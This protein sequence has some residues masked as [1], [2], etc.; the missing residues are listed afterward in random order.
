MPT[1]FEARIEYNTI[2][3]YCQ[4]E[5]VLDPYVSYSPSAD[6]RACEIIDVPLDVTI[7]GPTVSPNISL[8]EMINSPDGGG[9]SCGLTPTTACLN[10]LNECA[11]GDA[12]CAYISDLS[13]TFQAI[14]NAAAAYFNKPASM[15]L[16]HLRI[17]ESAW[18]RYSHLYTSAFEDQLQDASL[19]TFGMLPG[20]SDITY[21]AVGPYDFLQVWFTN[22]LAGGAA[23]ASTPLNLLS[24]GRGDTVDGVYIASRCNFLDSTFV[25]MKGGD[26]GCGNTNPATRYFNEGC[27]GEYCYDPKRILYAKLWGYDRTGGAYEFFPYLEEYLRDDPNSDKVG[28][29]WAKRIYEACSSVMPD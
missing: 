24:P 22:A 29:G 14:V 23:P 25:F 11:V 9:P 3:G 2:Y 27:D 15:A 19:R 6:S 13:P 10:A 21:S 26:L 1:S 12:T 18:N 5:G 8:N 17:I 28:T 20:C 16:V 7:D 4:N